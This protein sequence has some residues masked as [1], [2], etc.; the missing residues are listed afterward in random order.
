MKKRYWIALIGATSLWAWNS[1]LLA[2]VP[3]NA[4]TKLLSHRG[5]HQTFSRD[6]LTSEACT[7]T[8]IYPPEHQFIENTV[9]STKAAFAAGADIVEIDVHPT[10]DGKFVVFHDWTLDCRTDGEGVTRRHDLVYLQS[11]DLGYGYSADGGNT[12]PLRGLS[13]EPMPEL[14]AFL[15][16]FPDQQFLVNFKSNDKDEGAK[17][18]TFIEAHPQFRNNIFGVYGGHNPTTDVL[19]EM[20]D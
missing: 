10:T 4:S 3:E 7:A 1:S 8:R 17:F 5:V 13:K 20:E 16:A 18:L 14:A 15:S 9:A 12:F 6:G 19:A 11:L 2:P